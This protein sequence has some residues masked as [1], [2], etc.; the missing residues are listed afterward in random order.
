MTIFV[1]IKDLE[2]QLAELTARVEAGE[3]VV[4][5]RDGEPVLDWMP[6]NASGEKEAA[7]PAAEAV[8]DREGGRINLEKGW[9]YLREQ[10]I[11][12][13]VPYIADDFDDPLPEDFLLRPLP[14]D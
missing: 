1:A 7:R 5:T 6:R 10:G 8:P 3:T 14:P 11:T 12:N 4:V 2:S 13:P 9:A